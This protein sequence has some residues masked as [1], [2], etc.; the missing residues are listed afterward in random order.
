M[1]F[2]ANQIFEGTYPAEAAVWCNQKGNCHIEEISLSETGARRFQ[3]VENIS[4]TQEA[5]SAI[6]RAKRNSLLSESDFLMMPDYPISEEDR[7]D[8]LSYR[9]S[10][11]DLTSQ[12]GFPDNIVWP[13][14]PSVLT[15]K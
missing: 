11:R 1:S 5:L 10:L 9:Q 8:V 12:E 14:L 4:P 15:Q 6:A 7:T 2:Y 3:I 13:E